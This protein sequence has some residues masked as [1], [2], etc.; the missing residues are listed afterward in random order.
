MQRFYAT[1]TTVIL[2]VLCKL[3][4]V[5]LVIDFQRFALQMH[6]FKSLNYS[7]FLRFGQFFA[8]SKI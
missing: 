3:R 2:D 4:F 5:A 6:Q 7:I 8:K 1:K